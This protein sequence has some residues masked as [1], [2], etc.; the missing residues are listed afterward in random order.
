M[1]LKL[2]K[3][4]PSLQLRNLILLFPLV[5]EMSTSTIP[6][7]SLFVVS[8]SSSYTSANIKL[9]VVPR[10]WYVTCYHSYLRA[11][12][13]I[14]PSPIC[15]SLRRRSSSTCLTL[16]VLLKL[17]QEWV[18]AEGVERSTLHRCGLTGLELIKP[19]FIQK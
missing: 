19:Y 13:L 9:S 4:K 5:A 12:Q 3:R 14:D 10:E 15:L 7:K 2:F 6:S 11:V 16:G 18:C 8:P 17:C 1:L